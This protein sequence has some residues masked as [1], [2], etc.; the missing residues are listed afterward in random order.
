MNAVVA[1]RFIDLAP[2]LAGVRDVVHDGLSRSPKELPAWLFYDAAGSRLFERICEQP[3]YYPTRTE[4]AI[5]EAHAATM[6]QALGTGGT[7]VD[8]GAG[9]SRSSATR[10][11]TT[12]SS[13][14]KP[15]CS[16]R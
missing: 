14:S 4:A 6:A 2:D 15:R 16:K 10:A 5:F 9:T 8:L 12:T 13:T 1:P 11:I 3:E 7:L